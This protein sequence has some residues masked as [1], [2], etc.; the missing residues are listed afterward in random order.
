MTDDSLPA[1]RRKQIVEA[2]DRLSPERTE[3]LRARLEQA[4][5]PFAGHVHGAAGFVV[6]ETVFVAPDVILTRA[7]YVAAADDVWRYGLFAPEACVNSQRVPH[8][9]AFWSSQRSWKG[10]HDPELDPR[11]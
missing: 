1:A 2:L 6:E 8:G 11:T 7:A 3:A 4:R 9:E 10:P 5:A